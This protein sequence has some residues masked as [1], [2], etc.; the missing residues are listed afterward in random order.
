MQDKQ[1]PQLLAQ[2]QS[3]QAV[4][5]LQLINKKYITNSCV[6]IVFML[7]FY[8]HCSHHSSSV[9]GSPLSAGVGIQPVLA[10]P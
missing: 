1:P 9:V 7:G 5:D 10:Q 4:V 8:S 3:Q 2:S 6:I